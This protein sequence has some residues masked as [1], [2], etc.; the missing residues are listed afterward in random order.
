MGV[1][2][3]IQPMVQLSKPSPLM[4]ASSLPPVPAKLVKRIRDLEFIEMRELLPDN[5]AL[6]EHMEALPS[7][8]TRERVPHQ[9]E[10]GS[11]LT[12]IS[13]FATYVA[14]VSELHPERVPDMLMYLR[15][16]V[17]ESQKFNG[18]GWLTYDSVFRQNNAGETAKWNVLDPSLH[19]AHIV[20]GG[21]KVIPC[22]ICNGVDHTPD[23]CAV[24]PLVPVVKRPRTVRDRGDSEACTAILPSQARICLSWNKGKCKFPGSCY[25]RHVCL[26]CGGGHRQRDCEAGHQGPH[27]PPRQ[28]FD[29]QRKL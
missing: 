21:L 22:R 10:I 7:H 27:G 14:V 17:R 3:S 19:T 20:Q 2:P 11:L 15:L 24:A 25:Y 26:S 9:W 16:I 13:F 1:W 28:K 18:M 4:L 6:S 8:S 5:I 29:N 23:E 12:W